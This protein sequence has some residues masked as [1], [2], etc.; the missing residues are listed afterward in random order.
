MIWFAL[1]P[2]KQ[3]AFKLWLQR[4]ELSHKQRSRCCPFNLMQTS[5]L[6]KRVRSICSGL[7]HL[8]HTHSYCNVAAEP[9]PSCWFLV[10][11]GNSG[12]YQ[13][14]SYKQKQNLTWKRKLGT[15]TQDVKYG[16]WFLLNEYCF[17]AI[18][19]SKNHKSASIT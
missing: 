10:L 11:D 1:L 17:Y 5:Y 2:I 12:R 14:Q 15:K 13:Q 6:R 4:A 9:P 8:K 3:A 18:I 16:V 7:G 19:K